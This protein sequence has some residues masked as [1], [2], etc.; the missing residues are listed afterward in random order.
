MKPKLRE[1]RLVEVVE[2]EV[3]L[4]L[5]EVDMEVL[6]AELSMVVGVRDG[7]VARIVELEREA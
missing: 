5:L 2:L 7:L 3:E 6:A 1:P 4:V